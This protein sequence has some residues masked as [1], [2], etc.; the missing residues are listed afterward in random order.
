MVFANWVDET[1]IGLREEQTTRGNSAGTLLDADTTP[2][3]AEYAA[4]ADSPAAHA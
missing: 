3:S 1:R 2:V 4:E